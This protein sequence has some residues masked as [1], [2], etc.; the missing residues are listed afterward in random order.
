MK[1]DKILY[2][3]DYNPDQW[4]A[5]TLED[6]M[7]KFKKL[8]VNT[9]T[10]PV[11]SWAKLEPSEG[12]YT[13]EW[14]DTIL[15]VL[16]KHQMYVC[17]ATPTSAQP[18]WLSNQYPEVLPVDIQG[19]K[20]TH[21]MRV[22]FCVNSV[23]YR[24]RA[25]AIAKEMA[26]RYK[27]YSGLL[28]WHVANEYGTYCYCEHCQKKFREWLK[29]RYQTIENLNTQWHTDFWGRTVYS[30]DEVMLPTELNDD[31][32][33]NPVIQLDY[34]RFITDSTVDCFLNEANIIRQI[35]PEIPIY[36]NISGFIK[37]LDQSKLV[38][39][40]DFAA[41]DNYPT[42]GQPMSMPALKHDIMRSL[43]QG[44]SYMVAEQSPNQQN[45]QPYNKIKRPGELK[46]IAYQG[47]AH[48]ADSCLYF[49]MRQ[50]IGGQEKFHGAIIDHSGREDTRIFQECK[51]LGQELQQLGDLF[52]GAKTQA[53]VA[54]LFD[55]ENWWSLELT[56]GPT[57]DMNYLEQVHH[58]YKAFY[59]KNISV[60]MVKPG[61]PLDSYQIVVAPTLY[62]EKSGTAEAIEAFVQRGGT[63][64]ATYMLGRVDEQD[65]TVFGAYPGLYR[66][67]LGLRV[68]E[69]DALTPD[70]HN[71]ICKSNHTYTSSFLC[72]LI[73]LEG[74]KALAT[75]GDD[76]YEGTPCVTEHDYGEGTAYYIATQPDEQFLSDFINKVCVFSGVA[77]VLWADEG[78]EVAKR[79]RVKTGADQDIIF[80]INHTEKQR[81]VSLSTKCVDVLTE[82][83][84][85]EDYQLKP[86]EVLV[87][88]KNT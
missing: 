67:I 80:V 22:F 82:R 45:W 31:Y 63:F 36:S 76:F 15:D 56:S 74:A 43:K 50:S 19:R 52:I 71:S 53:S 35:T 32:R 86:R 40:M 75:Y 55:W 57:K 69:V 2:G 29:Q 62:M 37:K 16:A 33:F 1:T 8:G 13:F 61:D 27:N 12:V 87:L 9:V 73:E 83:T 5:Q 7:K 77:P 3:G 34:L 18:A 10:L 72:E 70:E 88:Q 47:F 42:P 81:T 46:T 6:D 41:W 23:K 21:G 85:S 4:D 24:E 66:K 38:S 84:L 79:T 51:Q 49:Q 78:V 65:R 30:F 48:G 58:Y 20:R 68:T 17:L 14:L 64:I 60:D 11:F 44:K 39:H 59:D 28:A 25:A 54:M 26:L